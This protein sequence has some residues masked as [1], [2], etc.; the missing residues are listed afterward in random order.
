MPGFIRRLS[1]TLAPLKRI[2]LADHVIASNRDPSPVISHEATHFERAW[3]YG[4]WLWLARYVFDRRFRLEE[5]CWGEAAEAV[6][7]IEMRLEPTTDDELLEFVSAP[8]LHGWQFPYYTAARETE[9][10]VMILDRIRL[11]RKNMPA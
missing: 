9:V 3:I 10:L 1:M 11:I 5:E 7:R 8:R 2:Y 4:P 6:A